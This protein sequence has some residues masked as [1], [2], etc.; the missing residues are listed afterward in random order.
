M[1]EDTCKL[2]RDTGAYES[3]AFTHDC[4]CQEFDTFLSSYIECLLWSSTDIDDEG[5]GSENFDGRNDE[6]TPKALE[7]IEKDCRDFLEANIRDIALVGDVS[8]CGHD[9]CLTR[10]GHG[11]GFWDR[12]LG[13]LGAR[14][15]KASKVYGTQGLMDDGNGGIETHA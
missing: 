8:Q 12:G 1:S 9:F 3:N 15:T 13:D 10:N 6:L 7:E 5:N 14:L 4:P 2:C 11:A